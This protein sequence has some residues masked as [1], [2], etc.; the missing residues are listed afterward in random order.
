MNNYSID[1]WLHANFDVRPVSSSDEL[2]I[3]C[4][5]CSND[6]KYHMYV[7]TVKPVAYCHK[8]GWAGG[9]IKLIQEH[10]GTESYAEAFRQLTKPTVNI[11]DYQTVVQ[12]L[13]QR[14][15]EPIKLTEMPE[16]Y[17]PFIPDSMLQVKPNVPNAKL[18]LRYA[19]KRLS[20]DEIV[21]YGIGYCDDVNHQLALR[22]IIPIERGYY[23]ARAINTH[24]RQKY[25]NPTFEIEDRLFNAQALTQYKHIFITEGAISAIAV[26]MDA[27]A[28][29]G[30]NGAT[31]LQRKRL[32]RSKV[33][34]FTIIV[35]PEAV[36]H[37]KAIELADYLAGYGKRI[38]LRLYRS[39]DPADEGIFVDKPYSM[40]MKLGSV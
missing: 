8:C 2:T 25:I 32:V 7:S 35:E 38:T 17:V 19:L 39:G 23:Q 4:P 40:A 14:K 11:N 24:S 28:T 12:Q 22:L 13:R 31:A 29:L 5:F 16:W 18:A 36:A 3:C 6:T 21:H 1:D 33:E 9:Y 10:T 20:I 37:R 30:A 27:V 26:G 34:R 15:L